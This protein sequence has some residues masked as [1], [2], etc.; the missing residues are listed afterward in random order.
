MFI[1]REALFYPTSEDRS[2]RNSR[3]VRLYILPLS[4]R[5]S[6]TEY[7]FNSNSP[8]TMVKQLGKPCE[9]PAVLQA[10]IE[11]QGI[12][13]YHLALVERDIRDGRLMKVFEVQAP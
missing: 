7:S 4:A 8:S 6:G 9:N 2:G 13:L 5:P 1:A 10:A 3:L 12:A 11:G